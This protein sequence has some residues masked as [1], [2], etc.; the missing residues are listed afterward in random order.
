[1]C[2]SKCKQQL[3]RVFLFFLLNLIEESILRSLVLSLSFFPTTHSSDNNSSFFALATVGKNASNDSNGSLRF[4]ASIFIQPKS[5][6]L[7]FFYKTDDRTIL[8]I[9]VINNGFDY[10]TKTRL[11]NDHEFDIVQHGE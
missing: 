4:L 8:Y 5:K 6:F 10:D 11:T 9:F 3:L 2:R 7:F 1:M